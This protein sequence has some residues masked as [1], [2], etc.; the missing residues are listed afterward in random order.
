MQFSSPGMSPRVSTFLLGRKHPWP[1]PGWDRTTLWFAASGLLLVFL[2]L[3]ILPSQR[4]TA[5]I[6]YLLLGIIMLIFF[7][8]RFRT[9]QIRCK[10]TVINLGYAF[11]P[12]VHERNSTSQAESWTLV[13]YF[14]YWCFIIIMCESSFFSFRIICSFRVFDLESN[15]ALYF[16]RAIQHVAITWIWC[17]TF[18]FYLITHRK[19]NC[20]HLLSVFFCC[21]FSILSSELPHYTPTQRMRDF[22]CHDP[23]GQ[24]RNP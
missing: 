12:S 24:N 20:R 14:I 19:R 11:V 6:G 7:K 1:L 16:D 9:V 15:R 2:G 18:Y 4:G 8:R 17:R 13:V 5:F 10:H 22:L 3:G 21:F 23:Y